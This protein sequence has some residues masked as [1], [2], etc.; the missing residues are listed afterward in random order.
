MLKILGRVGAAVG[1]TLGGVAVYELYV[2]R[3]ERA[4]GLVPFVEHRAS[5]IQITVPA[6]GKF[7]ETVVSITRPVTVELID[8]VTDG[9]VLERTSGRPFDVEAAALEAVSKG[10]TVV[11]E[12]G[13]TTT[14]W[15]PGE[16]IVKSAASQPG[17][18][19]KPG[20]SRV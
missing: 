18:P 4:R 10:S 19:E 9:L 7:P 3:Q 16:K 6:A 15:A 20:R 14:T 17:P 5:E 12:A 13:V 2:R 1:I 8:R 11:V